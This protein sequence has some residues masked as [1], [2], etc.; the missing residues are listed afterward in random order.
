MEGVNNDLIREMMKKETIIDDVQWRQL[1][2]YGHMEILCEAQL[3]KLV[4]YW[5]PP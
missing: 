2:W 4:M 1:V 3:L 5:T